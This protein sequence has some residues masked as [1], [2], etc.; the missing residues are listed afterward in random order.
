MKNRKKRVFI[1]SGIK[2]LAKSEVLKFIDGDTY[3]AI[4]SED[5][6]PMFVMMS[7]GQEGTSKGRLYEDI[8]TGQ[9][10]KDW[11]KQLWPLKA[12]KELVTMMKSR[13]HMPIWEQHEVGVDQSERLVVGSVVASTKKMIKG[14]THAVSIAYINNYGTRQRIENG[15]YDACSLE[16]VCLFEAIK[17]PIRYVVRKVKD[18]FG[19]A[20][21]NTQKDTPGFDDAN[22]LAV[23]TAMAKE[24]DD[25]EEGGTRKR[26]KKGEPEVITLKDVKDYIAEHEPAPSR[27]FTVEALTGDSKVIDAFE[28]DRKEEMKKVTDEN[29]ALKKEIEPLRAEKANGRVSSLIA[30]S[31]QLKDEYKEVVEYLKKTVRVDLEGAK[32]DAEAQTRVDEA[33]KAQLGLM[34]ASFKTKAGEKAKEEEDPDKKKSEEQKGSGEIDFAKAEDN[35]LIPQPAGAG[36]GEK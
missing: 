23:V 20:L 33:V 24:D 7:V 2:L 29:V 18:L 16:A 13:K 1:T 31:E 11:C 17:D 30:K 35:D 27:L 36:S 14:S 9:A 21:C 6:H 32:D 28:N 26:R 12:I 15:E 10:L 22:I 4:K 3:D 25:D 5:A 19:I 34:P 8:S